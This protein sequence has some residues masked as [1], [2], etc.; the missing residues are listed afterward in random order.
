[1]G[2]TRQSAPGN[3]TES[4]ARVAIYAQ[5]IEYPAAPPGGPYGR[6]V[7]FATCGP[8]VPGMARFARGREPL[9]CRNHFFDSESR[10]VPITQRYNLPLHSAKTR[11]G[12]HVGEWAHALVGQ[13]R[14]VANSGEGMRHASADTETIGSSGRA[15]LHT[16]SPPSLERYSSV[17]RPPCFT[18]TPLVLPIRGVSGRI[19][20]GVRVDFPH[21]DR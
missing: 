2:G 7:A 8:K 9:V 1:M 11:R 6:L 21:F 14:Y 17:G 19:I 12:A 4:P 16:I 18:A 15:S 13:P 5:T 20:S 3:S 10:E